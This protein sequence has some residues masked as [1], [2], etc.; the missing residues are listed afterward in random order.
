M[1]YK[2][3]WDIGA[4]DKGIFASKEEVQAIEQM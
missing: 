4:R 3:S 1:G 2:L